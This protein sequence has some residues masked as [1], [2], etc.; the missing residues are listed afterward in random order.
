MY[1]I[2]HKFSN[3]FLHARSTILV[4]I[5]LNQGSSGD[6]SKWIYQVKK[7]SMINCSVCS[8]VTDLK[9]ITCKNLFDHV[10]KPNP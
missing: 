2:Q 9:T 5:L 4:V 7:S 3:Y 10:L 8:A 1:T 6:R